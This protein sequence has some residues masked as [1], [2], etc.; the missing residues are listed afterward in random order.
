MS[1]SMV[2]PRTRLSVIESELG[3]AT[4]NINADRRR[5]ELTRSQ[6]SFV[7]KEDSSVR[8]EAVNIARENHGRIPAANYAMLQDRVSDLNRTIHRYVIN[9]A[10]S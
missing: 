4:H 5:G 2:Y 1:V 10:N 6:A 3:K 8:A 9:S 7:R